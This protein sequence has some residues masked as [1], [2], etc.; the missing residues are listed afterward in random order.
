MKIHALVALLLVLAPPLASAEIF[1][2]LKE[3]TA[4][5]VGRVSAA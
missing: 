2:S 3:G 5:L 1:D 4:K